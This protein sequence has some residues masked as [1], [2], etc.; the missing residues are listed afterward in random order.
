MDLYPV[1]IS[2]PRGW[3]GN[4]RTIVP[5][6]DTY[7]FTV[8]PISPRSF[9][10][11]RLQYRIS[12]WPLA[13]A[14]RTP[15]ELEFEDRI[16]R[17]SV[18]S[19]PELYNGQPWDWEQIAFGLHARLVEEILAYSGVLGHLHPTV[20]AQL[21]DY[22]NNERSKTDAV[23]LTATD[24]YSLEQLDELGPFEYHRLSWMAQ[25][26]LKLIGIDPD[27]ILDPQGYEK[28]VKDARR[29]EAIRRRMEAMNP[30]RQRGTQTITEEAM[31]FTSD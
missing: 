20:M 21:N 26:K 12:A 8:R 23:I 16:V 15:N 1:T 4:S 28:K 9:Q 13:R 31:S 25:E 19:H 5:R 29:K 11:W 2:L 27:I 18:V 22:F 10:S 3:V 24:S 14:N 30:K 7:D 17:E 6:F